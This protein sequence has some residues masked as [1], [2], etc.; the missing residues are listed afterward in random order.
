MIQEKV[1]DTGLLPNKDHLRIPRLGLGAAED[2][3]EGVP[4]ENIKEDIG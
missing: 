2:I 4:Q 1:H 3:Q